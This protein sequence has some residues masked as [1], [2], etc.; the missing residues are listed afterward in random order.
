MTQRKIPMPDTETIDTAIAWLRS[1]EGDNGES[2]RCNT[3]ANWLDSEDYERYVRHAA[4][5]GGVAVANLRRKL[6][7]QP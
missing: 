1:N 7:E 5:Q 2:E 4:R 3:V 6:A